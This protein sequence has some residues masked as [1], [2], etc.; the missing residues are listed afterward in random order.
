MFRLLLSKEIESWIHHKFIKFRYKFNK[1]NKQYKLELEVIN[2]P[3][4]KLRPYSNCDSYLEKK[5]KLI[6]DE[7]C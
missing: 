4:K 5:D 6:N 7:T 1:K 3:N 2:G